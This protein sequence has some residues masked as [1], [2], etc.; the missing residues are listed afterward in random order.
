MDIWQK[1]DIAFEDLIINVNYMKIIKEGYQQDHGKKTSKSLG[2]G[3]LGFCKRKIIIENVFG[4]RSE[5]NGEMVHGSIQHES[6]QKREIV[7]PLVNAIYEHLASKP[8]LCKKLG[9]DYD[10]ITKGTSIIN[11]Y[12]ENRVEEEIK[13]GRYLRG[14]VDIETDDFIIEIKTTNKDQKRWKQYQDEIGAYEELQ[15][16][17]YAGLRK[18]KLGFILKFNFRMYSSKANSDLKISKMWSYLYPVLFD[19]ELFEM[20]KVLCR[21]LFDAMDTEDGWVNIIGPEFPWECGYCDERTKDICR[22]KGRENIILK[23]EFEKGIIE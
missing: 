20:T 6:F 10:K 18:K 7:L 3:E 15:E 13:P 12:I 19:E 2:C 17:N 9:I 21:E 8:E 14:L 11:V 22:S 4:I 16:N 1:L 23:E 5:T